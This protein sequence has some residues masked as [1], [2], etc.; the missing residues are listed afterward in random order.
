M[1]PLPI[2]T[3]F[4]VDTNSLEAKGSHVGFFFGIET[5][6]FQLAEQLCIFLGSAFFPE[7]SFGQ[8]VL[9]RFHS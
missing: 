6:F 1:C 2:F 7:V 9:S 4:R 5:L 8:S 3:I